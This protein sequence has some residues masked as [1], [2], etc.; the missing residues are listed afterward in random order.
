MNKFSKMLFCSSLFLLLFPTA[1]VTAEPLENVPTSE[2]TL[3][4]MSKDILPES[5]QTIDSTSSSIEKPEDTSTESIEPK[6]V[7]ESSS[8]VS[9]TMDDKISPQADTPL[10]EGLPNQ[11]EPYDIDKNFADAIRKWYKSTSTPAPTPMTKEFMETIGVLYMRG[12]YPDETAKNKL[13]SMKGL[14]FATN[15][16]QLYCN[17]NLLTSLDVT[18]SP[19]LNTLHCF[20]NKIAGTLDVSGNISLARLHCYNNKITGFGN[21]EKLVS[22]NILYC[23]DNELNSLDVSKSTALGELYCGGNPLLASLKAPIQL[24]KLDVSNAPLLKDLDL[25]NFYNLVEFSCAGNNIENLDLS[26]VLGLPKLKKLDC[27][28]NLLSNLNLANCT[29]LEELICDNNRFTNNVGFVKTLK[30]ISINGNVNDNEMLTIDLRSH[31]KLEELSCSNS[32]VSKLYLS[33][34]TSLRDLNCSSNKQLTELDVSASRNLT[35]LDCNNNQLTAL[36]I[37]PNSKLTKLD[38]SVNKLSALNVGSNLNLTELKCSSNQISDITSANG[39]SL[40]T[41]LDASNQEVTT[42][43]PFVSND[44]EATVDV[45]RT[46]AKTGLTASSVGM[47]PIPSIVCT[48]DTILLRKINSSSFNNGNINFSY[49]GTKLAEGASSGKK[50]FN[51]TI[52]F[53]DVSEISQELKPKQRK[54]YTGEAVEWTWK[55]TG[56]S[57]IKADD[58]QATFKLPNG[59]EIDEDS[60]EKNGIKATINDINGTNKLGSLSKNDSITFTFKTRATGVVGEALKPVG[61]V[62]WDD[63]T[64]AGPYHKEVEEEIIISDD[65]QSYTPKENKDLALVSTPL[66]FNYGVQEIHST[67]KTYSLDSTRYQT[68]TNVVTKGFYTRMKDDRT[69]STGWKLT[70]KLSEFTDS[71]G[72]K[73][74]NSTGAS[75]KFTNLAIEKIINRD[76]SSEDID[77]SLAGK[78]STVKASETLIVGQSAKTLVSA[79]TGEG[80]GTWQL[81]MPFNK[82][83]LNLPPNAG[84]KKTTYT[85]ILTWSL[86]D[87][88]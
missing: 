8:E 61:R 6:E 25:N 86:D 40:L 70:A 1:L 46:T 74:P 65:Q 21:M 68:N 9:Q 79:K 35:T 45:L 69:T 19:K 23:Q 30:I 11:L 16:T 66:I 58:I 20:N 2:S 80:V 62:D 38:C 34:A 36:N 37:K 3:G 54:V 49:A 78:P 72:R 82:I 81:K 14:E 87:T 28:N 76:T 51:G 56:L 31:S 12:N 41:T 84:E 15:L 39:L 59:L 75:L 88:P 17:D 71:Y 7:S 85:A 60:I 55:I 47:Y 24:P 48:G 10:K 52:S 18:K 29:A 27:S 53:Y 77:P 5:D 50:D 43:R 13:T 63:A 83:S 33:G 57:S 67:A 64:L 73:M 26:G 42:P 22:L 44:L 32:Q 4:S